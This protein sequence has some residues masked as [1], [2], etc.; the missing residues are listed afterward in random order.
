[1]KIP[2][3]LSPAGWNWKNVLPYFIRAECVKNGGAQRDI[4]SIQPSYC[5]FRIENRFLEQAPDPGVQCLLFLNEFQQR[6]PVAGIRLVNRGG[7]GC[8]GLIA[9]HRAHIN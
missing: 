5:T 2:E 7:K 4:D 8:Y 6:H 9:C 1:M 3:L